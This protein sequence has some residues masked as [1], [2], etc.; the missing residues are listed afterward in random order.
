MRTKLSLHTSAWAIAALSAMACSST[1]L[2]ATPSKLVVFGDSLS[3]NGNLAALSHGTVPAAPYD[4]GRFSNGPVAVEVM[5]QTLGVA[6]ED[7]AIGGAK[8]DLGNYIGPSLN[9][10]GVQGQVGQYVA[11]HSGGL[12]ASALYVIWAGGNDF[13]SAPGPAAFAA[14]AQ[15]LANSVLTLYNAGARQFFI[16]TL[17]DLQY[18]QEAI[19]GGVNSQA[20]AHLLSTFFNNSLTTK[21]ADLQSDSAGAQIQVFDVNAVLDG[22][23]G[24]YANTTVGCWSGN[25]QSGVSGGTLCSDPQDYFLWDHVHPTAS[26]HRAVGQAFAAA[27]P[28]PEACALMLGGLLVTACAMNQRRRVASAQA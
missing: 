26:V 18:T 10:T 24:N 17:P 11:A 6:L 16:P 7:H 2:A 25:F 5:A 20:G 1:A 4:Q 12:D 21:M 23:R 14:S 27:V 22:I 19:A 9:G 3:D 8:T 15:N 13:F 28:E